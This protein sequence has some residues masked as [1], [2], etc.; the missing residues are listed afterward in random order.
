MVEIIKAVVFGIPGAFAIYAYKDMK[1]AKRPGNIAL[2]ACRN[3]QTLTK[4]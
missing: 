3:N 4:S 1:R 2:K